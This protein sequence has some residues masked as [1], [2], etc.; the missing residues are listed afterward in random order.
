MLPVQT[1]VVGANE[2]MYCAKNRHVGRCKETVGASQASPKIMGRCSRACKSCFKI[3]GFVFS[4]KDF[5][6]LCPDFEPSSRKWSSIFA[7][8]LY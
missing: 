8:T 3:V 7:S 5:M 2:C 6:D 1:G 4:C